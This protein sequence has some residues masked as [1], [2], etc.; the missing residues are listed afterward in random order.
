MEKI[1]GTILF[2]TLFVAFYHMSPFIGVPYPFVAAMFL[3]S[4]ILVIYMVYKILK[5]GT[6]PENAYWSED[7]PSSWYEDV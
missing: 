7:D 2:V 3:T 5:D 4:P 6:A 1:K